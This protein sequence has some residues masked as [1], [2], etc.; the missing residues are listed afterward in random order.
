VLLLPRENVRGLVLRAFGEGSALPPGACSAL[1][2]Y[3]LER[4]AERCAQ[5]FEPLCAQRTAPARAVNARDVPSC[6]AYFDLRVRA[7]F[8][9]T[10]G[11]GVARDLPDPGRAGSG[12]PPSLDDVPLRARAVLGRAAISAAMLA[13]L[14]A[15]DVVPLRGESTLEI[16]ARIIAR[17]RCGVSDGQAAFAIEQP[18]P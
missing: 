12:G 6:V 3:A 18:C 4:I 15:G 16:G 11:I 13:R 1:E 14:R 2:L 7:P 8:A 17:G 9:L 10:L 5:A